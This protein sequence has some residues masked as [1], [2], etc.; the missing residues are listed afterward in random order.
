V[1]DVLDAA[2]AVAALLENLEAAEL[3]DVVGVGSRLGE[4][5]T[6]DRE[7]RAARDGALEPDDGSP[8]RPLRLDDLGRLAVDEELGA[9]G[10]ALRRLARVLDDE[11]ALEAVRLADA[12]DDDELAVP[13]GFDSTS[14][15]GLPRCWPP[16]ESGRS[17]Q[18]RVPAQVH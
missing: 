12:P 7:R 2:Q 15:S 10:E 9:L 11:R 18:R 4:G 6:R 16:P 14:L 5:G 13:V 8:P 3:E 17:G 1:R